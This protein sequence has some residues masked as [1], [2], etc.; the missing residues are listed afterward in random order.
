MAIEDFAKGAALGAAAAICLFTGSVQAQS[1]DGVDIAVTATVA[2]RCG[3][4]S[5]LASALNVAADLEDA[6]SQDLAL[7]IDCNTPFTI[8][9]RA[10]SGRLVNRSASDDRSGYAFDKAYGLSVRVDT[11]AGQI[12][13]GRCLSTELRDGGDCILAQPSGLGSGDGVAI[14]RDAVVTVDW[15][16]QTTLG[17]RLAAGQY[18]D[19]VTFT[20]GARA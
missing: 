11:D 20:I 10:D 17:R 16:S 6:N 1:T 3:F 12:Q 8:S 18:S 9:A 4:T 13:S 5:R 15:P 19:T 2:E 14:G 7:R